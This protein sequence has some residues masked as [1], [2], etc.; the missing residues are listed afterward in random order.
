MEHFNNQADTVYWVLGLNRKIFAF[1]EKSF[2]SDLNRQAGCFRLCHWFVYSD[3]LWKK[4][5]QLLTH[6]ME[7]Y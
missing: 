2:D 5:L 1:S 3:E 7:S 4:M 6:L